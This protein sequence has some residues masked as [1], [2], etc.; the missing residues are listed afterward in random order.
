M[1]LGQRG[2]RARRAVPSVALTR[3]VGEHERFLEGRRLG[4]EAVVGVEDEGGTVEDE[5][6]LPAHLVR[7]NQRQ[8]GLA[9]AGDGAVETDV[10]LVALEGRAVDRDH[11]LGTRFREAFGDL[12]EPHVL[13]DHGAEADAAKRDRPRQACACEH[14]HLVED[15]VVGE[16]V[17]EALRCDLAAL[18]QENGVVK[19]AVLDPGGSE[20]ERRPAIGGRFRERLDGSPRLLL[21]HRLQHEVLGRVAGHDELGAD[22]EVRTLGRRLGPRAQDQRPIALQ[23]PH[24]GVELGERDGERIGHDRVSIDGGAGGLQRG[25]S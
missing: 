6:V 19:L 16:L 5:L 24:G 7:V 13:A 25:L 11:D 1:P 2:A 14:P 4:G 12:G 10:A 23:I 20:Q 9:D 17:L 3:P 22:H 8:L 21:K 15:P 18:E